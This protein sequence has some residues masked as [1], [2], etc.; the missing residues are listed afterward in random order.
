[1]GEVAGAEHC[2][3]FSQAPAVSVATVRSRL[4]A[5]EYFEWMCRSA[6]HVAV[7]AGEAADG[8]EKVM[9]DS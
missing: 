8:S 4:Q 7:G 1:M 9:G 2:D 3:A 6:T 5:R